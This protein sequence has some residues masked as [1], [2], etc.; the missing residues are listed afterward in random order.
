M[1][2]RAVLIRGGEVYSPDPLGVVDIL[3]VNDKIVA[4][5]P[6]LEL[7]EWS[8]G[9]RIDASGQLVFAGL[10]D[11]HVHFSGGGGEGGPQY[12]TPELSLTDLTECGLTTVVGILGTDGTTRSVQA[13]LAKAR[14][15]AFDGLNTRIYTGAYQVPTR[16][17]TDNPRND[18]ILIDRIIGIGEIAISD[19]RGSHPSDRELAHLAGEARTGGLLAGKAGV[20]HLHVGSGDRLLSPV[21]E[22]LDIADVPIGTMVPTHLNRTR[23]LLEDSVRYGKRGGF[24][25]IT[26]SIT[27]DAHNKVA[28]GPVEAVEVLRRAG[29]PLKQISFSTDAGGSAPVFDPAGHLV[30]MGIGGADS[31]WAGVRGLHRDLGMSWADAIRPATETPARILKLADVGRIHVGARADLI[32]TDGDKL[33]TVVAGGRV[34]VKE[35]RPVVFGMFEK[36]GDAHP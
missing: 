16:T 20:L 13:L 4:I 35:G 14:A 29:I 31:L 27:P 18:I 19:H 1:K 34:M 24:L 17:V 23:T 25:D 10:V 32:V 9:D 36:P 22:V 5:G 30:R 2:A 26:T 12:R 7:P 6:D 33:L 15:L 8:D 21:L 3:M 11:Q 28:V